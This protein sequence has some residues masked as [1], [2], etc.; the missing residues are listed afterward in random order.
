MYTLSGVFRLTVDDVF[1]IRGRGTVVTGRVELGSIRVGDTVQVNLG[2]PVRVDGIEAF[3]KRL[4]EATEGENVG[5]LLMSL[6]KDDVNRG[7]AI[8]A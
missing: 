4:D 7:D 3:R 8:S 1:F 5:L 2:P 6:T